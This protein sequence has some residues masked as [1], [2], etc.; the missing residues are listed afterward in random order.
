MTNMYVPKTQKGLFGVG[1]AWL[2]SIV[3]LAGA[4]AITLWAFGVFT[5]DIKGA[6]DAIK[7]RNSG[8]NRVQSQARFEQLAAEYDGAV[9]NIAAY[10][11][12]A[13]PMQKTELRG[14][15][16]HCVNIAADFNAESRKYTSRA[17][18]SAGLPERLD[19]KSCQGATP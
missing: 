17:W 11:K 14:L 4:V 16:Q 8:I 1:A 6:G 19:P 10:G 5:A 2:F 3:A 9:A 15:Q 13:T 18:K 12:P 7:Q